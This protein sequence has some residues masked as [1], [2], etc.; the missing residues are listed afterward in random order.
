[1]VQP[2]QSDSAHE[3]G[4][5]AARA[6]AGWHLGYRSWADNIVNA[7]LNP[8]ATWE[9]LEM[10]GFDISVGPLSN[11]YWKASVRM[12]DEYGALLREQT[13]SSFHDEREAHNWADQFAGFLRLASDEGDQ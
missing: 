8:Q 12:F 11:G 3:A 4:L 13:E 7:Y 2:D 10:A 5:K 1:M 9:L 6:Y